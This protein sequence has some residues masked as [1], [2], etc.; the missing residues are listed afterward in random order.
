MFYFIFIIIVLILFFLTRND[1]RES[2]KYLI[3]T[4]SFFMIDIVALIF[5]ISKDIIIMC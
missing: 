5:Y 1:K 3:T 2:D 4:L